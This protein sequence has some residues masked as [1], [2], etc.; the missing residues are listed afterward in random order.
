MSNSNAVCNTNEAAQVQS[1]VANTVRGNARLGTI[2][3]FLLVV[4][5]VLAIAAP[6]VSGMAMS[7]LISAIMIAAGMTLLFFC[8]KAES[9]GRGLGQFLLGSLTVVGGSFMLMEPVLT[10]FTLTGILLV[11]F[12][13]DGIVTIYQGIKR[14]PQEGWGWVVF[15]GISSLVL[16]GLL[17]YQWPMSGTYAV[18]ILVGIRLLFSGWSVAMLGMAG[19]NLG[20]GLDLIAEEV[21]QEADKEAARQEIRKEVRAELASEG[22]NG[23][24]PAPQPA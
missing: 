10:L 17:A 5:G 4:L 24:N 15:S 13:A 11:W 1:L 6:F 8:F 12:I 14:K 18:G 21:H 16:G 7:T 9:F 22:N 19:D 3:G 23:G 20:E 2:S